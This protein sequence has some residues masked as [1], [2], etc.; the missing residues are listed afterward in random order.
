MKRWFLLFVCL[1][2]AVPL[3]AQDDR[4]PR[5]AALAAAQQRLGTR[6]QS[7]TY[8]IL[9]PT[10]SA[11]LGCPSA[12]AGDLGR[13]VIP[14]RYVLS[15]ATGDYVVYASSDGTVVVLCDDKFNLTIDVPTAVPV[16]TQPASSGDGCLLSA[17]GAFANVRANPSREA[18]QV[19]QIFSG[20]SFVVL[21]QNSRPDDRWYFISAGWVSATVANVTGAGCAALPV[22]DG[23]VGSGAGVTP[24]T[25]DTNIAQTLALYACPPG[26]EGYMPPRLQI[27]PSTARVGSGGLPNV[28]RSQ[29]I[30]NDSIGARLGTIQPSR[31]IDQVINGPACS[32]GYVWWLVRVDNVQ[33]WTAE[34]DFSQRAYFLEPLTQA[35]APTATPAPVGALGRVLGQGVALQ[36][37]DDITGAARV[38][39]S[40]DGLFA[41]VSG[42]IT[43]GEG[44]AIF[45]VAEYALDAASP[46]FTDTGMALPSAVTGIQTLADGRVAVSDQ[47]SLF[48]F[49]K[50]GNDYLQDLVIPDVIVDEALQ[51]W[52]LTRDGRLLVSFQRG[53]SVEVVMRS[54]ASPEPLWIAELP[55][56]AFRLAFSPDQ[57]SVAAFGFD[58]VVILDSITG[59]QQAVLSNATEQFGMLDFTFDPT[60][61]NRLLTTICKRVDPTRSPAPCAA[62]EVTLWTINPTNILGVVETNSANP[63]HLV[64]TSDASLI[65]VGDAA[66]QIVV[67]DGGGNLVEEVQ[68][69]ASRDEAI[70]DMALS[71]DNRS[72]VLTTGSGQILWLRLTP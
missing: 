56:E 64:V 61:S 52:A 34:S 21:A 17:A 36:Q 9:A 19:A 72:L 41:L 71:A 43:I 10:T 29:P 30:V 44:Q 2:T 59:V 20:Q 50:Q 33:G 58:G 38:A 69:T 16:M 70:V 37:R 65:L 18:T 27:G 60:D 32:G 22:D 40:A 66:G 67:L 15:Y 11:T 23:R 46:R 13:Q 57:R 53:G 42:Q 25:T 49:R 3:A 51:G 1:M 35:P 28:I 24:P 39:V 47:A 45:V 14:Y 31:T 8:T 26:F 55:F 63:L 6:A 68:V 5:E 48:I 12:P 4:L 54:T 62:G 7:W